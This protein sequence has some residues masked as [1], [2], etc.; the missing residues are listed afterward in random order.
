VS[1]DHEGDRAPVDAEGAAAVGPV[2]RKKG[3]RPRSAPEDVRDSHVSIR[4]SA[5]EW[6]IVRERADVLGL[7]ATSLL[8]ELGLGHRLPPPKVDQL[9]A[10]A[11]VELR[12]IL[13]NL[14]QAIAL[15]QSAGQSAALEEL[16]AFKDLV[17]QLREMLLAHDR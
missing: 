10:E 7:T 8:R 9:T 15:A 11:L 3:G 5:R 2:R 12:A 6:A 13:R 16:R 1:G 14:N 4:F 17:Q